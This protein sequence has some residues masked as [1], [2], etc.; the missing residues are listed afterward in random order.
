MAEPL[1]PRAR[2]IVAVA[3]EL[4][5]QEGAGALTMRRLGARL[6]IRASSLYKHLPVSDRS[7]RP[8]RLGL[9]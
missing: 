7:R 3:R 4:L 9:R 2:Q 8:G 6:G 1:T 5:E